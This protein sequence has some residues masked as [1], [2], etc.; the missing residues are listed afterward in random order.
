M[1]VGLSVNLLNLTFEL[2]M[3]LVSKEKMMTTVKPRKLGPILCEIWFR[4]PNGLNF[5][6]VAC[7]GQSM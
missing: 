6:T 7:Q 3:A 5:M 1:C 2:F 4:G